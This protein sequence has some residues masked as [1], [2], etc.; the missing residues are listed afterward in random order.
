MQDDQHDPFEDETTNQE[1]EG[2][3]NEE[4]Q[5]ETP[6]ANA[7]GEKEE[8]EAG[9]ESASGTPPED[10]K[11]GEDKSDSKMIPEH[12]F[13]A[14][15]KD[16]QDKLEAA[17]KKLADYEA[18]P[19]PDKEKDPEGYDL[20]SRME[21]SKAIMRDLVPDYDE[22]MS[23]YKEMA[24]ANPYLNDAVAKHPAPAKYA[25]DVVKKNL[26]IKELSA[27]KQSDEWKEFQEYKKN[28]DAKKQEAETIT[29]KTSKQVTET[30]T[31]KVPNLNRATNVSKGSAQ[32]QQDDELFAGAL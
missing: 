9:E 17:N 21:T 16:V 11:D 18:S 27:L 24:E 23:H 13:K 10:K 19:V 25:Y 32:V 2:S 29:A 1:A 4:Q 22:V 20:Y 15:I 7:E 8:G 31:T 6:D 5:A 30:L 3:T 12:R 28:K 26:E 14:A